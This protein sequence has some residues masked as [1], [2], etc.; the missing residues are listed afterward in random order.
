MWEMTVILLEISITIIGM[1]TCC[2][3]GVLVFKMEPSII[4]NLYV[5]RFQSWTFC[6]DELE[7]SQNLLVHHHCRL[8]C[9][10]FSFY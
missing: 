2:P 6:C 5:S 3:E 8:H 7:F 10:F 9:C 4:I 1:D